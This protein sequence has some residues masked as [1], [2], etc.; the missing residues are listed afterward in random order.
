[1]HLLEELELALQRRQRRA[2][3]DET[4]ELRRRALPPEPA[5][6][7]PEADGGERGGEEQFDR[8]SP[9][10]ETDGRQ[11]QQRHQDGRRHADPG[12]DRG[13][14]VG[15]QVPEL[16][17]V[18]VIEPEELCEQGPDRKE[19]KTPEG[20]RGGHGH[21]EGGDGRG[22]EVG[23]GEIA[24][25][26]CVAPPTPPRGADRAQIRRR[27]ARDALGPVRRSL[28]DCLLSS[29]LGHLSEDPPGS[30]A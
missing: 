8:R 17:M 12:E 4:D 3:A 10:E 15:G 14:L 11:R 23:E 19:E 25:P 29:Q 21:G 20:S 30:C 7:R 13:D 2:V 1:M 16:P 9:L 24:T 6:Q 28:G 26:V 5:S 27:D 22:A 18:A